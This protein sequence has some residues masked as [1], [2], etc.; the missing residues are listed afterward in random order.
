MLSQRDKEFYL[1]EMKNLLRFS[2][3][4]RREASEPHL[5]TALKSMK[6]NEET[7]SSSRLH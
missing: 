6:Q 7:P 3:E 1:F 5:L 4:R 2:L